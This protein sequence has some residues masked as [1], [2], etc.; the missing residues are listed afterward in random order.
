MNM[1]FRAVKETDLKA[2]YSLALGSGIGITTLP[3]NKSTLELRLT[4]ALQSFSKT[5]K[6]PH[7]EYYLF[8]LED[9]DKNQI[10]GTAAIESLTGQE[11]PFYSYRHIKE[12]K[13]HE[14]LGIS[15]VHEY[16]SL[17][18]DNQYKTEVCTLYLAPDYRHSGNGL[19]LSLARFLFMHH[20]PERFA[21]TIIAELR[22]V[23]Q[24]GQSPFWD[25][26]GQHFFNMPFSDADERTI[27]TDKHFIADLIPIHPIYIN[28]LP[29]CAQEVIGVADPLS[30]PAM[31]ILMQQGFIPNDT[32]DIF[33]AGP[34]LEATR[35]NIRT[36]Q[37]AQQFTINITQNH[38]HP[39]QRVLLSNSSLAFK[40]T[41]STASLD[42]INQVCSIADATAHTLNL[43]NGDLAT[44]SK[45]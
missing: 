40:A 35:N 9:L 28:L 18:Y 19:L 41:L 12:T 42:L 32:V 34:T 16:L 5:V 17:T 44:I 14:A 30:L 1:L 7:N 24:S 8:V 13:S 43:K 15:V 27:T 10:V 4:K 23:T 3:K 2:I 37:N 26:V 45:I 39:T 21:D 29:S 33:D 25:A 31:N 38:I 22:G 36:I 6:Q 20:F 11:T